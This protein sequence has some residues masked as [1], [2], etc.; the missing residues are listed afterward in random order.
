MDTGTEYKAVTP[1]E[2][3]LDL[4]A[5]L[6]GSTRD[7]G[8]GC[9]SKRQGA[10]T[11]VAEAPGNTD[12]HKVTILAPKPGF[13][14]QLQAPV[15]GCLGPNNQ[16]SGTEPHPSADGLPKVVLSSQPAT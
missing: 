16:Q 14:Q 11:L 10:R 13:C 7:V 9:G 12:W 1:Q 5:S 4:R 15:L 6:G 3:G 8:A 2:H